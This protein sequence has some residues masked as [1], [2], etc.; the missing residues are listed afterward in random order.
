[1]T[2]YLLDTNTVSDLVRNPQGRIAERI[3]KVGEARVSTSIIV[4]AE[5]RYGAEKKGSATL[6][7]RVEE[8]LGVL[9][10][11]PFDAPADAAYGQ[12]R[13]RL[14]RAGTPI[15][16]NDMLIAAQAMALGCTVVTSNHS[17]FARVPGLSVEDWLPR[18][19][20]GPP[21]HSWHAPRAHRAFVAG[22]WPSG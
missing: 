7:R 20:Q 5:L 17:K 18:R 12:I 19:E 14:E 6:K 22:G 2:R 16:G 8:I 13:A 15:S 3:A 9:E 4:A 11:H 21:A 1:M 10:V